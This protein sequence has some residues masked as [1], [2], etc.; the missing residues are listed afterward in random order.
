VSSD[1]EG[2]PTA[3]VGQSALQGIVLDARRPRVGAGDGPSGFPGGALTKGI[4]MARTKG[5]HLP[6]RGG[7]RAPRILPADDP[8]ATVVV[9]GAGDVVDGQ[10]NPVLFSWPARTCLC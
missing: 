5:N 4:A 3:S 6:H 2:P 9:D 7:R 8:L 1:G 10:G